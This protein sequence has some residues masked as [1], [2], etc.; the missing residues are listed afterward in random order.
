M[1]KQHELP[2]LNNQIQ[3]RINYYLCFCYIKDFYEYNFSLKKSALFM[4]DTIIGSLKIDTTEKLLAI[5]KITFLIERIL[6]Y[7]NTSY[8]K[9]LF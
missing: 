3:K 2:E 1:I 9:V 8:A 6:I 7:N 4:N 5:Q